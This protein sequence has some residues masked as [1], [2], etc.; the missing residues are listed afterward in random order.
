MTSLSGGLGDR[1]IQDFGDQWTR[2]TGNEGY[3]GSVELLRDICEPLV[4]IASRSF[5]EACA[6]DARTSIRLPM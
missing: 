1:T 5:R 3:Y 6:I 2:Y 4:P